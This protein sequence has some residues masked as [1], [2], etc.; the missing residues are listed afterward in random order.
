MICGESLSDNELMATDGQVGD[1][2]QTFFSSSP[3]PPG[4]ICLLFVEAASCYLCVR[5]DIYA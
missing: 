4:L 5:L 2:G 1:P 3:G